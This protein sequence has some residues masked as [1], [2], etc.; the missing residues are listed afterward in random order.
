M[1][2]SIF[3]MVF[4]TITKLRFTF[5][6]T[7]L[8]KCI[9]DCHGGQNCQLI[10][11]IV[12]LSYNS[13]YFKDI[14][15]YLTFFFQYTLLFLI[16]INKII[17]FWPCKYELS[18]ASGSSSSHFLEHCFRFE[19]RSSKIITTLMSNDTPWFSVYTSLMY[20]AI[21]GCKSKKFTYSFSYE[22]VHTETTC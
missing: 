3:W 8:K 16:G 11:Q 22:Y 4:L 17:W 18:R 13:Y 5:T 9:T 20:T 12:W 2:S 15:S 14:F 7:C 21:W 6:I 1:F 19:C 10:G